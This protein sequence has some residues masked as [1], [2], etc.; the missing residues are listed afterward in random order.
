MFKDLTLA[1]HASLA[2]S[3]PRSSPFWPEHTLANAVPLLPRPLSGLPAA[4]PSQVPHLPQ[5]GLD[6]I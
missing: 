3:Q 6:G 2:S 1:R 4:S 5:L